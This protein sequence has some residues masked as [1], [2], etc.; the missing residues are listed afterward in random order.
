MEQY[1]EDNRVNVNLEEGLCETENSCYCNCHY[2]KS[3]D[4]VTN[5]PTNFS[6]AELTVCDNSNSNEL[7]SG[8]HCLSDQTYDYPKP[9]EPSSPNPWD[10][11]HI[12]VYYYPTNEKCTS[13][14]GG[15]N[16]TGGGAIGGPSGNCEQL[17][18]INGKDTFQKTQSNAY[19]DRSDTIKV[20]N[21]K[22]VDNI[23]KKLSNYSGGN[24]S[25]YGWTWDCTPNWKII[26]K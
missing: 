9:T 14:T 12:Y 2:V 11:V 23:V 22:E 20:N 21:Q 26:E 15:G 3:N 17:V 25:G 19:C 24:S 7:I 6:A 16:T 1:L 5:N 4:T 10:R 13:F 18:R 8:G